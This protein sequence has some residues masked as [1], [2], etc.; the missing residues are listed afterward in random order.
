MSRKTDDELLT[1]IND[2]IKE[3]RKEIKRL[4]QETEEGESDEPTPE[5]G[6]GE[7]SNKSHPQIMEREINLSLINDKLNFVIAQL[8]TLKKK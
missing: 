1:E 3:D 6:E 5:E 8:E 7:N 4:A 2:R